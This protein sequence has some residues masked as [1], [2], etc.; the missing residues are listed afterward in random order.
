M[1]YQ[2]FY[3][4]LFAPIEKKIGPIDRDTIVAIVGFDM[5]GPLNL[6]TV[7]RAHRRRFVT[8]VSCEL[9]VRED[10]R[11]GS[12]GPFELMMTCND[13]NWCRSTLTSIGRMTLDEIFDHHHTMDISACL[14][15][16]SLVQGIIFEKFT[17]LRVGRKKYG[18]LYCHGVTRNE[19]EFAMEHGSKALLSRLK[20]AKIY[21]NTDPTRS[22]II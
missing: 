16:K 5:G 22:S 20:K 14:K 4:K 10:Q 18:I 13:E 6:C 15:K 12:L 8:Y 3:K 11:A 19:L 17:S 9:A 2:E 21:P 7:G 1:N